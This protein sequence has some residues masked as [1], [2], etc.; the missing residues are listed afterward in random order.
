MTIGVKNRLYCY[1]LSVGRTTYISRYKLAIISVR[2]H[3]LAAGQDGALHLQAAVLV[4]A[5]KA[6]HR[7]VAVAVSERDLWDSTTK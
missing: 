6:A 7:P 5:V 4:A 1:A 2:Y 3:L